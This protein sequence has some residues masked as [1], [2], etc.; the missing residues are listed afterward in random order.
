MMAI[1]I[2]PVVI[3]AAFIALTAFFVRELVR[4]DKA[5]ME[6]Y[7]A[8]KDSCTLLMGPFGGYVIVEKP[9]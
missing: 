8:N 6:Y 4:M 1:F 7:Q 2:I 5:K 9:E 3:L